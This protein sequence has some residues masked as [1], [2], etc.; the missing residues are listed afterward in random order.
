MN[1]ETRFSALLSILGWQG[2]TIHE[3]CK[4]IKVD[5]FDFL[6]GSDEYFAHCLQKAKLYTQK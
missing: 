6:Y 1:P 4:I 2:G 5:P 3:A